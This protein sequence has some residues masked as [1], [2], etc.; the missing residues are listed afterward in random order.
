[1]TKRK[2]QPQ[3]LSPEL[4]ESLPRVKLDALIG[5]VRYE[6]DEAF[7][8]LW[9]KDP[10]VCQGCPAKPCLDF[11]P[12]GVYRLD[13]QGHV[14][15]GYQACLECG[16]CRVGCPFHNIGWALPRGGYGVAYKLG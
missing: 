1:M 5:S 10:A 6:V 13:R 11:C 4:R 2:R 16:S 8:H 15:V 7:A 3:P 14:M 12:A 9:I